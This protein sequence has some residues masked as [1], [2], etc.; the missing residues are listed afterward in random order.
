[1]TVYPAPLQPGDT[2]AVVAPAGNLSDRENYVAGCNI[3]TEMGYSVAAREHRWPG[4]GY[5]ADRDQNRAAELHQAF[6]D[7]DV[8][9]IIALRGGFGSLRLLEFLDPAIIAGS[10]KLM[11]GFSDISILLNYF[12][13]RLQMVCLHGPGVTSLASCDHSSIER[14]AQSLRGNWHHSLDEEVEVLR[15]GTDVQGCLKGGNLSSLV[16]LCGTPWCPDFTDSILF[17][18]DV[19]EAPYRI[20]RLFTQ[21]KHCG[22]FEQVNGIILGEFSSGR[23]TDR[24]EQ[25][26]IQEFVWNRVFELTEGSGVPLWGN[27]PV[28][29]GARN[30]SLPVGAQAV[31]CSRSG[32]LSFTR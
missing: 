4:Y 26:R 19:N 2:I 12:Q 1:M 13:D 21:L 27:F 16:T 29:H 11:V 24:N 7:P 32:R 14:L 20:D 22:M 31:M 3:L 25:L 10:P 30:I 15:T 5:L 23:D 18:E 8:R 28:G 6:L 17:L 9:G